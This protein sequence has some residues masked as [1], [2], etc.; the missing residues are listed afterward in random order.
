MRR[1]GWVRL[2]IVASAI[3]VPAVAFW[4]VNDFID[5]WSELDNISIQACVDREGSPNFDVDKCAHDAGAYKTAFQHENIS[6]GRYW[7][8]ALGIAFLVD[9]LLTGFLL[10]AFLVIRW[11]VRGFRNESAGAS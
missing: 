4:E 9:L 10:G 7:A 11:V 8:E 3:F 2:W 1:R 6:P 5:T